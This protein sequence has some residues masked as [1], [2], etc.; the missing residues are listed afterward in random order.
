MS[1][2]KPP[3]RPFEK[4]DRVTVMINGV[5]SYF[6]TVASVRKYKRRTKVSTESKVGKTSNWDAS[7]DEWD[8][9]TW[10]QH[11]CIVHYDP[12]H[13]LEIRRLRIAK[14]LRKFLKWKTLSLEDLS[15]IE[16]IIDRSLD[17]EQVEESE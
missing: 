5:P 2:A 9:D 1:K 12:Q 6:Q 4:G 13:S 3:S 11:C 10:A 15:E 16:A 17:S 7:G 14:R 8:T